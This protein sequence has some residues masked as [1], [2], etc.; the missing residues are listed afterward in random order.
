MTNER[1]NSP[2]VVNATYEADA[3]MRRYARMTIEE[4]GDVIRDYMRII[5]K[6]AETLNYKVQND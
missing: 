1:H 4:Q 2:E 3:L 6:L 5:A